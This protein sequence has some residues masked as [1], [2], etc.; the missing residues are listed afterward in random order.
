VSGSGKL[1]DPKREE[2]K[3]PGIEKEEKEKENILVS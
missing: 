3:R 1:L 2:E